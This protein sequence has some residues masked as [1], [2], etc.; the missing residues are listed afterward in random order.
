MMPILY[1]IIDSLGTFLDGYYL[2]DINTTPLV[3]VTESTFEDV[4]NISYELTFFIIAI[5]IL[6]YIKGIKK[7]SFSFSELRQ[8]DRLTAAVFETLGQAFY[9]YAMSG[10]AVVAAPLIGS[11]CIVSLILSRVFLKEKLSARKYI[12]IAIAVSGI[13]LMGILEGI[14]SAG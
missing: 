8:K 11:Y 2:D 9:V 7:K 1:C 10:S 3:S 4:A 5:L 12:S 13:V 6:I 14:S